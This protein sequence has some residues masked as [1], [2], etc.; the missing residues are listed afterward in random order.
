MKILVVT[1]ISE[2]INAFIIPHINRLLSLGHQVEIATKIDS[3]INEEKLSKEVKVFNIPFDRN[4]I[5]KKNYHA[6]RHISNLVD[7]NDYDFI[8]THTPVASTIVRL[9]KKKKRPPIIYTAHGFHFYEGAPKINWIL[10]YF[11]EKIL[12]RRTNVLITINEEDF[13]RAKNKFFAK[14]TYLINGIGINLES[15]F[16]IQ[17]SSKKKKK[18]LGIPEKSKIMLS[19]G[20]LNRNKNHEAVIRSLKEIENNVVY[21]VCGKG[22][23]DEYLDN[24]TCD[25]GLE[26]KVFFLGYRTDILE[27]MSISDLF[28]FPSLREGLPVSL[29]EAMSMGLPIVATDIRGNKD[30]VKNNING[31]LVSNNAHEIKDKSDLIL[32]DVNLANKFKVN[33]INDVAN[34]SLKSVLQ[35]MDQI[36]EKCGIKKNEG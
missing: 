9:L 1:T 33:N 20:E 27:I 36:Y 32:N 12:S 11:L 18:E 30:I 23:L 25:L 14:E 7:E 31:Y 3:P 22:P 8:H 28:V 16:E 10:Y 13:K 24:L 2:T 29:L 15:N 4:P 34:Y 19:V 5:S 26:N 21:V 17:Y 35:Q 6:Y